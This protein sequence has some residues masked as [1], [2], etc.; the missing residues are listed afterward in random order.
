MTGDAD[1]PTWD[2]MVCQ[3][4]NNSEYS[5]KCDYLQMPHH[6][7]HASGTAEGYAAANPSKIMIPATTTLIKK[8]TTAS[9]AKP[10]Y[11]V[12]V[13]FGI[14][15]GSLSATSP[16]T[17]NSTYWFAGHYGLTNT[18]NIKCFFTAQ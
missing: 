5:L 11:D 3:H 9:N 18:K 16:E 14:N 8:Y 2:F 10:S 4:N 13:K 12:L 1:E 6:A 7:V 15:P 17:N